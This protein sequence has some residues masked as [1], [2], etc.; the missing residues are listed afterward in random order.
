M[1]NVIA[2][3]AMME[4]GLSTSQARRSLIRYRNGDDDESHTY[5][6]DSGS[7]D[8]APERRRDGS[9]SAADARIDFSTG[10]LWKQQ[11]HWQQR[12][13]NLPYA[14]Q[15]RC[16]GMPKPRRVGSGR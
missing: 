16:A 14:E 12:G 9:T 10:G 1:P 13:K 5:V 15:Q 4:S 6:F 8:P 3:V 7:F 2:N 11:L